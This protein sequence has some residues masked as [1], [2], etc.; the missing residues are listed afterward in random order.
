[1]NILSS[2]SVENSPRFDQ[3]VAERLFE[4]RDLDPKVLRRGIGVAKFVFEQLG[5]EHLLSPDGKIMKTTFVAN[6]ATKREA[7]RRSV[8]ESDAFQVT[9]EALASVGLKNVSTTSVIGHNFIGNRQEMEELIV[10]APNVETYVPLRPI[11]Q[12]QAA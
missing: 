1:M 5:R 3:R 11:A 7:L 4:G 2:H 6:A 12:A 8:I 10:V 9:K